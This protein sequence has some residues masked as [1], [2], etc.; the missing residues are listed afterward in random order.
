MQP[1]QDPAASTLTMGHCATTVVTKDTDDLCIPKHNTPKGDNHCLQ[2]QHR[3][4]G[5][6]TGTQWDS[7]G[8]LSSIRAKPS[9]LG[10]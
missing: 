10:I 6:S 4:Q 8:Q 3:G 5:L 7:Q 1:S 9:L 2:L